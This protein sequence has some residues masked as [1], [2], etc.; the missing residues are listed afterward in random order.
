MTGIVA[1]RGAAPSPLGHVGVQVQRIVA[2]AHSTTGLEVAPVADR[3]AGRDTPFVS[4]TPGTGTGA[5]DLTFDVTLS[6]PSARGNDVDA[7]L[8]LTAA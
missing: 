6:V 4:A 3:A 7:G 5:F 1:T 2:F 8:R